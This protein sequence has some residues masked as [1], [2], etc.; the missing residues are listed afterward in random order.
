MEHV[1]GAVITIGI[2]LS[3]TNTSALNMKIQSCLT[4]HRLASQ[5]LFW[6][7]DIRTQGYAFTTWHDHSFGYIQTPF[8]RYI[9]GLYKGANLG[10]G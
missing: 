7:E 10:G 1:S 3:E 6:L 9:F 4:I 2:E 8:E 5:F